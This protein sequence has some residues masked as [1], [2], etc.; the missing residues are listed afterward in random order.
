MAAV[1]SGTRDV[2]VYQRHLPPYRS[3]LNPD[4]QYD[5]RTH[6]F[7]QLTP[8]DINSLSQLLQK[9]G[10]ATLTFS[11][12]KKKPSSGLMKYKSLLNDVSR[13][14]SR[15]NKRS[16]ASMLA[17]SPPTRTPTSGFLKLPVEL[18]DYV[19][20][21][22]DD[23]PSYRSCMSTCK[24]LYHL[25]KPH[26]YQTLVFDS[27]YRLGQF[28][29]YLRVNP[30]VGAYVESLTLA[31][32]P[33]IDPERLDDILAEGKSFSEASA[34]ARAGWRDWKYVNNP[35]YNRQVTPHSPSVMHLKK[36]VSEAGP[37][38][39]LRFFK[40]RKRSRS[41]S[42]Q[43]RPPAVSRVTRG[44]RALAQ[45]ASAAPANTQV[46]I[47]THS[48]PEH[49]HNGPVGLH[50]PRGN[51]EP[52]VSFHDRQHPSINKFLIDYAT[53]RDVPVG[54]IVHIINLCPNLQKLDLAGASISADYEVLAPVAVK[55]QGFDTM[56]GYKD[57]ARV[58]LLT[59]NGPAPLL[60]EDRFSSASSIIST[61]KPKYA[62]L[63]PPLPQQVRDVSYMRKGDGRVFLSDLN[64]KALG[65]ECLI[66]H[67]EMEI[68]EVLMRQR[69]HHQIVDLNLSGLI[70]L[71][72]QAAGRFLETYVRPTSVDCEWKEPPIDE[73]DEEDTLDRRRAIRALSH[74][75]VID[76]TNSG[77]YMQ[78][79]WAKR[80]DFATFESCQLARQ[81][82]DDTIPDPFQ[83]LM[84]R[85][86]FH[87]GRVGENY[88]CG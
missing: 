12:I 34:T 15:L 41:V 63:L 47:A 70:W 42:S 13:S 87:R 51:Q 81:I 86:R 3:L 18:L 36:P 77:M 38:S 20:E 37:P 21:L 14:F 69:R 5:Y 17:N 80:L 32:K 25:S 9:S 88:Y 22:V 55:Y 1:A 68:L 2:E 67:N 84:R 54:Y 76:F 79:P 53:S 46:V 75:A 50:G 33:G 31:I 64:V 57:L 49:H 48:G 56:Q 39:K 26:Y 60:L 45:A 40:R 16:S 71:N 85:E 10:N 82:M 83:E 28:V 19:L 65:G 52:H 59:E 62:S 74:A 11:N 6:K 58:D 7:V 30:R 29:S 44:A 8:T 66:S 43:S 24:R 4:L 72:K 61:F 73:D 27:A 78:L 35:L 23:D